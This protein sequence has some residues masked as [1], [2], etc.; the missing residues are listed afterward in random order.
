MVSDD[1][2]QTLATC[3][4]APGNGKTYVP[5]GIEDPIPSTLPE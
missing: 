5:F 4:L 3:K 1:I 2:S